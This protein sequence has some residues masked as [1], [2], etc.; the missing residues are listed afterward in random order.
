MADAEIERLLSR[1]RHRLNGFMSRECRRP[2]ILALREVVQLGC[3]VFLF[4]SQ[5]RNLLL[6][7][8]RPA[9]RDL[10]VVVGGIS[11]AQPASSLGAKVTRPTRFGGLHAEIREAQLD[12]WPV[13]DTWAFRH[14]GVG[15]GS[16]ADLPRTTFL[17][18]EAVTAELTT[19]PGRA[20]RIYAHGFFESLLNRCIDINLEDNPFPE[21]CV[22]RSLVTAVRLR[23][24]LGRKL[25]T[26]LPIP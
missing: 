20:R 25:D 22:V 9:V 14:L 6:T 7:K 1:L 12:L 11:A 21:L 16:F 13:S 10:D 26:Q 4:G 19:A 8:P 15:S 17:D 5:I 3:P 23:F 24:S 18:I 2:S